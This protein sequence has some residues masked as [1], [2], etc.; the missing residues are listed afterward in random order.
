MLEA[1]TDKVKEIGHDR[2]GKCPAYWQSVNY[3]G[4]GDEE[5]SLNRDIYEFCPLSLA[6]RFVIKPLMKLEERRMDRFYSEMG[7][8]IERDEFESDCMQAALINTLKRHQLELC[9]D[10]EPVEMTY[11]W[12][13]LVYDLTREYRS[14]VS[15]Q[16]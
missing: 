12:S 1:L 3:W 6:S 5:C 16:G 11:Y 8:Q 7:K 14:K 15:E 10:G 4:E 2:C 13:Q 9:H